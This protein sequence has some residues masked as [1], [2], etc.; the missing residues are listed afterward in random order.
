MS[1]LTLARRNILFHAPPFPCR[2]LSL[3]SIFSRRPA[4]PSPDLIMKISLLEAEANLHVHDVDKQ[5]AF[6]QAL[7]DADMRSSY[8]MVLSRWE[9]ACEFDPQSPLL[10]SSEAFRL[11]I[12]ALVKTGR[13]SAVDAA[14]RRRDAIIGSSP[15]TVAEKSA[16]TVVPTSSEEIARS[17]MTASAT[18]GKGAGFVSNSTSASDSPIRVTIVE[19]KTA[20]V[21]KFLRFVVITFVGTF[22]FLVVLSVFIENSGLLKAGPSQARFNP[23]TSDTVK[24]SDVHGV[25]EAKEELL[26]VVQFLKDP[27]SVSKLGGKLPRGVLLSGPP[28]T[29][30]TMLARAVAGEAGVPFFYA[31][32]SEFEEM[33]VGVGAKRVRELFAAARKSQPSIVFI[34]ELDAVGGKRNV[35][36]QQYMRQTLNQLLTEMDGFNQS[37]GVVVIGATNLESSLDKAL[38]RPGRFDRIIHIPLPDVIGRAKILAH[39]MRN[40]RVGL[41][42]DTKYLARGTMG[43]SGADLESMVNY[44]AI[45]AAKEHATVVDQKHFEWAIDRITMGAERKTFFLKESKRLETAYHEGGHTLVGLYTEG[46]MPFHKVTCMPRGPA[47]GVT[48][49]RPV[50]NME[51]M[52]YKEYLAQIDVNMGGRVA[53]GLV[54]GHDNITSGA[55]SDIRTASNIARQMVQYFGF[56]KLGPVYFGD[57]ISPAQR[58]EVDVEV[59]RLVNE[60][61]ARAKAILTE[62][63]DELHLLAKALVEHETLDAMEV[64]KVIKGEPIR[65]I[66]ERLDH[67]LSTVEQQSDTNSSEE[68]PPVSA[69]GDPR[70]AV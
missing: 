32:G 41:D 18:A 64:R 3:G 34:D 6:F 37:E 50:D 14:A 49:F 56:S 70:P 33:Y 38:V 36:D 68:T 59:N 28:G 22:F 29:G 12:L 20:W 43:F 17:V 51:S 30:K 13:S 2:F 8:E 61:E 54:Y 53:E 7:V 11:Y 44:A 25:D 66:L 57:D 48:H 24:F 4:T 15:A 47:L 5:L 40:V 10:R 67:E 62:K 35:R 23:S 52:T 65:G 19:S 16:S 9:R 39:H 1:P 55:S 69:G 42:V 63:L 45:Q 21:P 46:A 60:G 58:Q 27:S 31:S 26:D